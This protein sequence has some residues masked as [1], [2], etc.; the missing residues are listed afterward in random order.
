M[1]VTQRDAIKGAY[2]MKGK[3]WLFC[4]RELVFAY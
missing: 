3:I 1:A 4:W 2:T